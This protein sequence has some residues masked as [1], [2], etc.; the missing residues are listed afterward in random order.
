MISNAL[1]EPFVNDD[2][3]RKAFYKVQKAYNNL[4]VYNYNEF[5]YIG[6]KS[7]DQKRFY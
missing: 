6:F 3:L 7:Y 1:P 5:T 4:Y 2:E